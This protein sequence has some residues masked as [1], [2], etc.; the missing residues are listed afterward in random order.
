MDHNK[1]RFDPAWERA[2]YIMDNIKDLPGLSDA[3]IEYV[4]KSQKGCV[5]H[6]IGVTVT[7][8]ERSL[9]EV[10]DAVYSMREDD[11]EIWVRYLGVSNN[12]GINTLMLQAGEEKTLVERFKKLFG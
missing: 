4:P 9:Q 12:F 2:H 6:T 10:R 11:P 7:F 1:E 8:P 3:V 5:Y